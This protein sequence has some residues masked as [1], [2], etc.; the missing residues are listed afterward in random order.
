MGPNRS[1]SDRGVARRT[2]PETPLGHWLER[3]IP[4]AG[5]RNKEAFRKAIDVTNSTFNN[6]QRAGVAAVPERAQVTKMGQALKLNREKR[7]ELEEVLA[8]QEDARKEAQAAPKSSSVEVSQVTPNGSNAE[9]SIEITT[10]YTHLPL[11]LKLMAKVK[12]Y[13]P[14]LD[15]LPLWR[16]KDEDPSVEGWFGIG[17]EMLAT[18]REHGAE[19]IGD[20]DVGLGGGRLE[21]LRK[22]GRKR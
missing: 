2:G 15:A 5:F 10:S 12:R 6:W 8:A 20:E 13:E 4:A 18:L 1:W 22:K 7:A 21:E 3:E 9:R 11:A 14:I 16:G 17:D 19:G